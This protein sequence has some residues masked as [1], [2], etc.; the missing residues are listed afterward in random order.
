MFTADRALRALAFAC[1]ASL[2]LVGCGDDAPQTPAAK[3]DGPGGGGHVAAQGGS[4]AASGDAG[5]GGGEAQG[6][7]KR[8]EAAQ[9]ALAAGRKFLLGTQDPSGGWGL[10]GPNGGFTGMAAMGVMAAT[11]PKAVKKNDALLK[12]LR[13]LA[14]LQKP[15]GAIFDD[16]NPLHTNYTTSVAVGAFALARIP[17]FADTQVAGRDYLAASQIHDDEA[18]PSFG[19]FPY[20][21]KT[22]AHPQISPTPKWR[23]KRSRMPACP[24]TMSRGSA[25]VATCVACRTSVRPMTTSSRSPAMATA[26]RPRRWS[27]AMTAARATSRVAAKRT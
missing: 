4:D 27:P 12:A 25:C 9:A 26:V 15:S 3:G 22:T 10:R 23:P 21:Q 16:E 1:V 5:L 17:E 13:Y 7:A 2:G 8:K 11:P 24:R 6:A 18:D 20:K 14:T 19:G